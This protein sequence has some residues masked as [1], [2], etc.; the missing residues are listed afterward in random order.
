MEETMQLTTNPRLFAAS[1]RQIITG[2]V[3]AIGSLALGMTKAWAAPEGE[4]SNTAEAIHQERVFKASRDRVYT[5]L[6]NTKQFDQVE[7][8]ADPAQLAMAAGSTPT[9]ISSEAG[10]TF[11]LFGGH[12]IGRQI[13]LIPAKRIVQAWREV[14][15]NEG[16]YSI[17]KFQLVEESS[18][19][20]LVFD[21]TGFPK[22]RAQSLAEGWQGHYWG[23]LEKY[24]A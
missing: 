2:S 5:A 11:T 20:R 12:I 6:T 17:A 14:S 15:W 21:H 24:L 16:V 10:G 22:G 1:R 3:A 13:E 8:L 19:T 7:R 18:G 4:I 9:S 23:P